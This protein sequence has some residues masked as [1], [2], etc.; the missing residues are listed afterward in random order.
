MGRV[1]RNG[2]RWRAVLMAKQRGLCFYCHTPL[3]IVAI[4]S[5]EKQ[6]HN[7]AT[8]DHI[9]PRCKGGRSSIE[10]NLVLACRACNNRKADKSAEWLINSLAKEVRKAARKQE[11]A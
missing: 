11:V 5:G 1:K 4:V 3:A 6:P 7:M 9:V 8:F 2:A 10:S